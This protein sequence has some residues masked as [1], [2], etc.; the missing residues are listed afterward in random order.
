MSAGATSSC[1]PS[2]SPRDALLEPSASAGGSPAVLL[3]ILAPIA[4]AF[5]HLLV[6]DSE[7]SLRMRSPRARPGGAHDLADALMRLDRASELV[8]FPASPATEPLYSVDPFE[9]PRASHACSRRTRHLPTV[10][11]GCASWELGLER[12]PRCL[13]R[14]GSS[15]RSQVH[16]MTKGRPR[17]G[18][19][20]RKPAASY[21]PRGLR[22]KYHR[23][24]RA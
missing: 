18:P 10:C 5:I 23:R 9:T 24:E 16:D 17:G 14:G 3:Y 7:S 15:G 6:A 12:S 8:E 11:A 22:P 20:A 21:S 19:S 13:G 1:R 4:S 2:C